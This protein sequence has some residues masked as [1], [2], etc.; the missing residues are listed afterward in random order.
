[1]AQT[2]SISCW[3]A[4][5][6]AR[7]EAGEEVVEEDKADEEEEDA[8]EGREAGRSKALVNFHSFCCR[9][10]SCFSGGLV[11]VVLSLI[12]ASL[13]RAVI[14]VRGLWLRG[15]GE[16]GGRGKVIEVMSG[17]SK[18]AQFIR[19]SHTTLHTRLHTG[20]M[21]KRRWHA[22]ALL[23]AALVATSLP[24]PLFEHRSLVISI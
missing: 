7:R 9:A 11:G 1:M 21:L 17:C 2:V 10:R 19:L 24:A 20:T 3:Q 13:T 6:W 8:R 5:S 23:L 4:R 12:A 18:E 14:S 15:C 22:L 16:E